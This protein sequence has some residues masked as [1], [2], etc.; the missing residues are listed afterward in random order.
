MYHASRPGDGR[1]KRILGRGDGVVARPTRDMKRSAINVSDLGSGDWIVL[2]ASILLFIA[3][4]GNWWVGGGSLNAAWRSQIYFF[5][6]LLLI[7]GTI[8][9]VM[10]PLLLP[11]SGSSTP[12]FALAPV[13]IA[14]G[15][16]IFLATLYELGRYTGIAQPTV[17]PG[18]GIYLALISSLL[19][20]MG[21]LVKWGSRERRLRPQQ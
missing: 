15:F 1:G 17:S 8:G 3:L 9:L 16:V 7:L 11:E 19:Y 14:I 21:A 6:M 2:G 10:Y 4:I 18:F 13:F 5:V 20:L 12:K